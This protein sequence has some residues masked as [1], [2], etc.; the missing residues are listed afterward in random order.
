MSCA[1]TILGNRSQ[2][3]ILGDIGVALLQVKN[4]RRL[5][6][7]DMGGRIGVSREMI[8]QYIAGEAEMGMVKWLR[9][10]EAWPELAEKLNGGTE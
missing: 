3:E 10:T 9:A 1:Q 2:A 6:L 8:A 5:T 4:A 7:D